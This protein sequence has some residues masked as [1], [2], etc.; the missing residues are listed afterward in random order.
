[1]AVAF[2]RIGFL[3]VS[4]PAA[5]LL[6]QLAAYMDWRHHHD[7]PRP[8]VP[9]LTTDAH[10]MIDGQHITVPMIALRG[11]GHVFTL[12]RDKP[13]KSRKQILQEQATDPSNPMPA[14]SLDFQIEQYQSRDR[15]GASTEIC[16]PMKRRWAQVVCRGE[17]KDVLGRL[18]V[19]SGWSRDRRWMF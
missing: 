15:Y 19:T 8:D 10:F 3:L 12:H 4:V 7:I 16:Q 2:I 9:L 14:D 18:P 17:Q 11:P 1:M 5:V 6:I 13:A